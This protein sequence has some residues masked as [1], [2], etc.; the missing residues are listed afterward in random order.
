MAPNR[1]VRQRSGFAKMKYRLA[2]LRI[3]RR[4]CFAQG[5]TPGIGVDVDS[6]TLLVAT[7][8]S[9]L[10]AGFVKGTIGLGLPTVSIGLLGLLMPPSQAAAILVVPSLVTNIWQALVGGSFWE[11]VR[12]LWPMLV[13][14]CVGTFIGAVLLPH[15]DT[16]RATVW[17]GVALALYAAL[18]LVKVNFKVPRQAETWLGLIMGAATGAITVA[19]GIFVIPG[20]PYVQSLQFDRDK[21]VQALGLS[22]TVSTI[23]LALALAYAGQ[24]H[25]SIAGPSLLAL[26]TSLLGM[27]LGQMVRGRVRAETF[28]L[29]FFIGLL[30][31]GAH[32]ALHEFL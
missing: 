9:F 29:W 26:A 17:L 30:V 21:L 31:L 20:T 25:T 10:L 2:L 1:S 14:I 12:R 7:A 28:R 5:P 18:G 19:T 15:D 22:F 32:L 11:L 23:M 4:G 3:A 24:I 16:G 27:V 8:G 13:G 6:N